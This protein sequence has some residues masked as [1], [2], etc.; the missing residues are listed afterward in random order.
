MKKSIETNKQIYIKVDGQMVIGTIVCV[1][2]PQVQLEDGTI[3]S[4]TI[5]KDSAGYYYIWD[6][7][8]GYPISYN[9]VDGEEYVI[10][11]SVDEQIYTGP[12]TI[13]QRETNTMCYLDSKQAQADIDI[14]E[15]YY[16]LAGKSNSTNV[17][18]TKTD[19]SAGGRRRITYHREWMPNS[20]WETTK[21]VYVDTNL[22]EEVIEYKGI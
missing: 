9:T 1:T 8:K 4:G 22:E 6:G 13:G 14:I 11:V 3:I 10:W 2:Y 7:K 19:E 16:K 17:R 18:Y 20:E 12:S 15:G 5:K 21:K